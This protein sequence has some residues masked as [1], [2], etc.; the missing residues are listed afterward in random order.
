MAARSQENMVASLARL[1]LHTQPKQ[2]QPYDRMSL[3]SPRE[4]TPIPE[5]S[6]ESR[7]KMQLAAQIC[8]RV[9]SIDARADMEVWSFLV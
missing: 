6:Y 4:D 7:T 2:Y 8:T 9:T 3:K 5:L 1:S